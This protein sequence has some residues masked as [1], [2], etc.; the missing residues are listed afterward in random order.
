MAPRRTWWWWWAR[1][2]GLMVGR[3]DLSGLSQPSWFY[4]F[5]SQEVDMQLNTLVQQ[6]RFVSEL[7]SGLRYFPD[8]L[9]M[10]K[11]WP[12]AWKTLP[13]TSPSFFLYWFPLFFSSSPLCH[14][15]ALERWSHS[16]LLCKLNNLS[17]PQAFLFFLSPCRTFFIFFWELSFSTM[18]SSCFCSKQHLFAWWRFLGGVTGY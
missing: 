2:D 14:I 15:A 16:L 13:F 4:V 7:Q 3:D 17:H 11:T 18:F 9:S 5:P 6:F 8:L 10:M 1:G 12:T